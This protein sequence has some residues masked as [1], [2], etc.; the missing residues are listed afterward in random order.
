MKMP[1]Q[2]NELILKKVCFQYEKRVILSELSASFKKSE[3]TGIFGANGSGKTTLLKGLSNQIL[4]CSGS[5]DKA[6]FAISFVP[7]YFFI[8]G[9]LKISELTKFFKSESCSEEWLKFLERYLNTQEFENHFFENLS[10]GQK[11]RVQIFFCLINKPDFI[12]LDEPMSGLDPLQRETILTFFKFLKKEIGII[13]T[14][15]EFITVKDTLDKIVTIK[16][17]KLYELNQK[18]LDILREI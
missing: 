14:S 15:H 8:W 9:K 17:K 10:F 7:D 2:S 11:K 12:L 16:S 5:I 13:L 1:D 18:P 6:D 4:P 3:I